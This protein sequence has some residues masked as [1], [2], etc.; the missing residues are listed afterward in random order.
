MADDIVGLLELSKNVL[1]EDL[2][3]L[4]THLIERV[5]TPDDTLGEDLVLV[6]SDESA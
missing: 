4:H 2:S 1:S 3:E 6:E 5:D